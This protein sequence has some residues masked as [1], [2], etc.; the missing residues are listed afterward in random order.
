LWIGEISAIIIIIMSSPLLLQ[1]RRTPFFTQ[2][3][4]LAALLHRSRVCLSLFFV[5]QTPLVLTTKAG[6]CHSTD[7]QVVFNN[8]PWL[9]LLMDKEVVQW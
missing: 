7:S 4:I 9:E 1:S 8:P 3:R 2:G 6:V 5:F